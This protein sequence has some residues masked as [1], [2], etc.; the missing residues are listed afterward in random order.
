MVVARLWRGTGQGLALVVGQKQGRRG[1]GLFAPLLADGGS[2]VFGGRVAAVEL[3]AGTI[4]P[5]LVEA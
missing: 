4:Q 1:T 3:H 5:V 2:A